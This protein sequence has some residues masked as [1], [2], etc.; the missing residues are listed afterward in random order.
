MDQN[1][2]SSNT[3]GS[4]I[5]ESLVEYSKESVGEMDIDGSEAGTTACTSHLSSPHIS[6]TI[7]DTAPV[8]PLSPANPA[9]T[10][11]NTFIPLTEFKYF[12]KLPYELRHMV[13]TI[14]IKDSAPRILGIQPQYREH[15]ALMQVCTQSRTICTK[16]YHY[17]ASRQRTKIFRFYIDYQKDVLYMNHPFTLLG[18]K[19]Q[20]SVIQA[21]HSIYPEFLELIETLSM[22]LKEVRNLTG[23][24]RGTN[25]LW[26]MLANWCPAV[27]ELKIVINNFP[28]NGLF[29]DF[30]PITT[31]DQY[32][33]MVPPTK[34]RNMEAIS[35]SWRRAKTE[36]KQC[37]DLKM[38]LVSIDEK[39]RKVLTK[40]D[41]EKM[42]EEWR[43]ANIKI[44]GYSEV[45]RLGGIK[46]PHSDVVCANVDRLNALRKSK[47]GFMLA[48]EVMREMK[49][50]KVA[51][52]NLPEKHVAK[53]KGKFKAN[54]KGK[55][56]K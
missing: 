34:V 53:A 21:T 33:A 52:K 37:L 41:K 23:F 45:D 8:T 46:G 28:V 29:L 39:A 25:T 50:K 19:A 48:R 4:A 36:H 5:V 11:I 16:F 7:D 20:L 38:R 43:K 42:A 22:N 49:E 17:C 9:D 55:G 56:K 44:D 35:Q 13:F 31:P 40:K 12:P 15:P 14:A 6:A 54:R 2:E 26:R 10:I 24:H 27:K 3:S 51:G 18:G 30:L 1:Q 47:K 32:K